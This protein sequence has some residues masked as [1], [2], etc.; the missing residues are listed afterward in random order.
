MTTRHKLMRRAAG[1]LVVAMLAAGLAI[2]SAAAGGP[3][4]DDDTSV[5]EADIEFIFDRGITTG[6]ADGRFC[7][8]DPV[9]RGQMAAFLNRT[10]G[11]PATGQDFFS[12]DDTSV[13]END[14]NR[15]ANSSIT[16][17]CDD[18]AFCPDDN[19]TRGQMAAFLNRA[20]ADLW[21]S[22]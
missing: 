8:E 12:D 10:L 19:V 3:F 4:T 16:T 22:G 18:D 14:I 5:H 6:C 11:L 13:F 9:T 15:L 7:P 20:V 1:T 17:G 21:P 2:P